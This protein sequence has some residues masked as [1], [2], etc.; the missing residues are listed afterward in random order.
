MTPRRNALQG[1]GQLPA[2]DGYE[3]TARAQGVQ[4]AAALKAGDMAAAQQ[5]ARRLQAFGGLE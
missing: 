4:L 1:I 3:A 5:L 2:S